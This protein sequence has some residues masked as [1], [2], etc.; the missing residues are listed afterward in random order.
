MQRLAIV[1]CA[2][3]CVAAAR[4]AAVTTPPAYFVDRGACPGEC[5]TYGQWRATKATSLYEAPRLG[6]RIVARVETGSEVAAET[7]EVHTKPGKFIVRK[8]S[9]PYRAGDVIWV[10]TYLGEGQYKV[11]RDGKMLQKRYR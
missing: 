2:V 11:W 10:Y 6:T 4:P 9:P 3:L 7:G 1:T 8:E 5:C